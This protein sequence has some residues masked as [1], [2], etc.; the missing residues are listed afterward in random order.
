MSNNWGKRYVLRWSFFFLPT[1]VSL[2]AYNTCYF[3]RKPTPSVLNH[4]RHDRT[5]DPEVNLLLWCNHE[6]STVLIYWVRRDLTF[7]TT[8]R[9]TKFRDAGSIIVKRC[10]GRITTINLR[11]TR[12]R[13]RRPLDRKRP[14]GIWRNVCSLMVMQHDLTAGTSTTDH[15]I[16]HRI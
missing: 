8:S 1:N 3:Q 15:E 13:Q 14:P 16:K 12:M 6:S 5:D 7:A 2:Y 10:R 4:L 11:S 9:V